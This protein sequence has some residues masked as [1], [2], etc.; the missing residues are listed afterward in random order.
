VPTQSKG[1]IDL[2]GYDGK[3]LPFVGVRTR[4]LMKGKPALPEWSITRDKHECSRG[5]RINSCANATLPNAR[6]D[7]T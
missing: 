7:L 1:E 4:A 3:T 6:C 2:V 5:P